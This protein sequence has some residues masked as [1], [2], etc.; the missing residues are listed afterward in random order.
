MSAFPCGGSSRINSGG[1][2]RNVGDPEGVLPSALRVPGVAIL[3]PGRAVLPPRGH[4]AKSGDI[5]GCLDWGVM[6][7][8]GI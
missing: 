8:T 6:G 7:S 5:F 3:I 1:K 2:E 4:W